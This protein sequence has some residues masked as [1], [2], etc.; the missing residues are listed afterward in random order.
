M[1][2]SS[3]A[4]LDVYNCLY[5]VEASAGLIGSAYQ[6]VFRM[7]D[8]IPSPLDVYYREQLDRLTLVAGSKDELRDYLA[9]ICGNSNFYI[10]FDYED[11][12]E[13]FESTLNDYKDFM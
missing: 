11:A 5:E 8:I 7:A 1:T 6:R 2:D 4:Y 9:S 3:T 10:H 12:L 13:R